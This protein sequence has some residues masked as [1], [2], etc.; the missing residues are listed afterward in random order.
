ML[1]Q[2]S[3]FCQLSDINVVFDCSGHRANSELEDFPGRP[4]LTVVPN[5]NMS[6]SG[7]TAG[8]RKRAAPKTQPA[9]S[10]DVD[11]QARN[12]QAAGVLLISQAQESMAALHA[13]QPIDPPRT[14][15]SP[16]KVVTAVAARM[17]TQMPPGSATKQSVPTEALEALVQEIAD[18]A[19]VTLNSGWTRVVAQE[20][21]RRE[22]AAVHHERQRDVGAQWN[23]R[24]R[25]VAVLGA[26]GMG[27]GENVLPYLR[28]SVEGLAVHATSR[29][30]GGACRRRRKWPQQVP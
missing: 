17:R 22:A 11:S 15:I 10:L 12:A 18:A 23:H 29:E 24:S 5:K 13:A 16:E 4:V 8:R 1:W 27:Y 9:P 3:G 6:S 25:A 19:L 7:S 28:R 26:P 20:T 21:A 14:T 2:R 30:L